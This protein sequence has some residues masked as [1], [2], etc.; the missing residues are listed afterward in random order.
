MVCTR[1]K[2]GLLDARHQIWPLITLPLSFL[3]A[4]ALCFLAVITDVGVSQTSSSFESAATGDW[5]QGG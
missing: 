5:G 3:C 1:I 2:G 4:P